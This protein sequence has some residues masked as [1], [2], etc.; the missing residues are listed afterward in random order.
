LHP[1]RNFTIL[2]GHGFRETAQINQYSLFELRGNWSIGRSVSLSELRGEKVSDNI[3][4]EAE[5][6]SRYEK[7]EVGFVVTAR[8]CRLLPMNSKPLP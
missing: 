4:A 3:S 6:R 8:L 5:K 2:A 7:D 1:E